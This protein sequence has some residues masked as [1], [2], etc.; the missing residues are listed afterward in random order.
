MELFQLQITGC[1]DRYSARRLSISLKWGF[2]VWVLFRKNRYFENVEEKI[3]AVTL[4][5]I[6]RVIKEYLTEEK[7]VTIYETPTLTHTQ[8]Y[9]L[10][11]IIVVGLILLVLV[12]Y[13]R[14][15]ARFK[16]K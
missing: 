16:N 10:I 7:S 9:I 13:M 11:S 15:H 6:N 3:E 8:F 1:L 4:D 12:V 14:A 2:W 5:D